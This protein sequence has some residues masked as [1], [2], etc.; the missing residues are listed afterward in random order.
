MA[1]IGVETF[2]HVFFFPRVLEEKKAPVHIQWYERLHQTQLTDS[3]VNMHWTVQYTFK[4]DRV[5]RDFCIE[6]HQVKNALMVCLSATTP[7]LYSN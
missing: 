1:V 6:A 3:V 7:K 4:Q 5:K 2:M